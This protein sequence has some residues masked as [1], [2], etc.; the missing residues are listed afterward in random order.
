MNNKL[1]LFFLVIFV[2]LFLNCKLAWITSK[3]S[4]TNHKLVLLGTSLVCALFLYFVYKKAQV[5]EMKEGMELLT[6]T[7]QKYC[8]GGSF[9]WNSGPKELKNY[10]ESL[11]ANQYSK[12]NCDTIFTGRHFK[13][14]KIYT[15]F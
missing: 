5:C 13:F 6:I 1:V 12:Y 7:P 10:C 3:K 2:I 11:T 8:D 15:N 4:G 9:F 14:S